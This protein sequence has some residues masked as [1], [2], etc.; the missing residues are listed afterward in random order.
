MRVI[1]IHDEAAIEG[2]TAA[3][4]Y[5]QKRPGLGLEFQEAVDA[6]LDLLQDEL[7]PSTPLP[8]AAGKRGMRRFILTRFPYDVVFIEV[9]DHVHVIAIAHHSKR[10]GFWRKRLRT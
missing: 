4:W 6:A 5:E 3:S 7:I 8:G 2:E 10:P 9:K 1:R